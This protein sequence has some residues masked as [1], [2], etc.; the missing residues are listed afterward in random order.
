MLAAVGSL[1]ATLTWIVYSQEN[2]DTFVIYV[3]A[4]TLWVSLFGYCVWSRGKRSEMADTPPSNPL[5]KGR[6]SLLTPLFAGLAVGALA[7]MAVFYPPDLSALNLSSLLPTAFANPAP[8]FSLC[9][10]GRGTNCVADGDTFWNEGVKI[11]MADIE[12]PETHPP[13]CA[14]EADMGRRAT[15]RLQELLNEGAF[16][17]ATPGRD[18]D[19]YR[20]KLRV[21]TRNGQSLGLLLVNEGLARKWTG[22][23]QS[24]C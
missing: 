19:R 23:R 4:M 20:R 5:P 6:P 16:E 24:W 3:S 21:I 17:L 14:R 10:A 15:F 18:E 7:A 2:A 8:R 1:I 22:K 11:R 12:G 9:L 13:R